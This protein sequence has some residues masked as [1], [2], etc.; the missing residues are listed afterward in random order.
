[1]EAEKKVRKFAELEKELGLFDRKY[2]GVPYWQYIR[3]YVSEYC[4]SNRYDEIDEATIGKENSRKIIYFMKKMILL[5]KDIFFMIRPGNYDVI[6]LKNDM[7]KD[8]FFDHWSLPSSIS[9][10]ALRSDIY[11]NEIDF[12]EKYIMIPRIQFRF[13]QAG[14]RFFR[15]NNCD[16]DEVDFLKNLEKRLFAE[17]GKAPSYLLMRDKIEHDILYNKYTAGYYDRLFKK[18]KA[19]AMAVVVYYDSDLFLRYKVA[20]QYDVKVIEFQHGAISNHISYLFTDPSNDHIYTPDYLLTFGDRHK[21]WIQLAKNWMPFSVGYPYQEYMI[22]QFSDIPTNDKLVIIY[23]V[24]DIR[25]ECLISEFI[26]KIQSMGYEAIVKL[27]PIYANAYREVYPIL[28][29]NKYVTFVT[30][31]DKGIYYWLKIGRHHIMGSTTVGLEA[32]AFRHTNVCI[33]E[34][35]PHEQTQCLIDW[36]VARGFSTVEELVDLIQNPIECDDKMNEIREGLW[37]KNSSENIQQFF[38]ELKNHHWQNI[39]SC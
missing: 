3:F 20:R 12:R 22:K 16:N 30:S 6:L 23:P 18:T 8:R 28:S 17:F 2:H 14:K 27:H 38:E 37:K 19:K 13:A 15:K 4:L 33:I 1:M 21:D 34:S 24:E 36:G 10:L 39:R 31:Q 9:S 26:D 25:Y 11:S 35:V 32:M 7:L 5:F 29:K